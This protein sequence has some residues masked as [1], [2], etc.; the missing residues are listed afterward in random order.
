MG[1]PAT[2]SLLQALLAFGCVPLLAAAG[3]LDWALH[4]QQRIEHSA[5]LRESLLHLLMIGLL[6]S[7][8][9]AAL[10]LQPTAGLLALLSGLLLLHELSYLADLKVATAR[11]RIPVLEQWVH[12]FQHLLPW[13]GLAGLM[14]LSP[15]QAL[16]LL[17]WPGEVADW[18]L[19]VKP[20]PP[21][22]Y[23]GVLLAVTLVLN[24]LPF[25]E[26]AWRCMRAGRR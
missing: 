12:G 10:L 16:A 13:A 5:G 17:Q 23:T 6:G 15:A 11:R 9:L 26:E 8:I 2:A 1:G 18:A 21:W 25:V 24:V 4:R 22:V 20:E 7:A 3:V 19:R 14:A